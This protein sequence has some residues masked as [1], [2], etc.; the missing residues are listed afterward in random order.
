MKKMSLITVVI[1]LQVTIASCQSN[2]SDFPVYNGPYLGQIL[3]GDTPIPFLPDI[4]KNAHTS[5]AFSPDGKQVFWKEMN[6]KKLL[7]M[8]EVNGVWNPPQSAPFSSVFYR[9]DVPFFAPDGLRLYF[10][11]TKPQN[12]FKLWSN[13][14]IWYV[15]KKKRGWSSPKNVGSA[16]NNIYKHWQF[17]V[18]AVG[19]IYFAGSVD[20]NHE[21]WSIYKSR[22]IDSNYEIPER[23]D[24]TINVISKPMVYAQLCPFISPDESYIIY[25]SRGRDDAFGSRSNLYISYK[26][27]NN[28]WTSAINL[29]KRFNLKGNTLCP[30][31]SPDGNFLFFLY[32]NDG[33]MWV[34]ANFIEK[35]RPKE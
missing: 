24:S 27:K 22:F 7:F 20:E 3:P 2:K 11:T 6:N 25:C 17:S 8:E 23:L 26:T 32:S 18:S 35:L 5:V 14:G 12:W 16:I 19:S 21:I 15:K 29:S 31:V 1:L 13:E 4:I 33:I 28:S 34:E 9:Q 30:I 10:I